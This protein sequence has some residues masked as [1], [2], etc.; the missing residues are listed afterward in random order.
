MSKQVL[1]AQGQRSRDQTTCFGHLLGNERPHNLNNLQPLKK[2]SVLP[3]QV[4]DADHYLKAALKQ[5]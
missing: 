5:V 3:H 4:A 2:R 1:H